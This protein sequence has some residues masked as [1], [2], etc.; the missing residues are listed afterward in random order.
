MA[1]EPDE[2]VAPKPQ[3]KNLEGLSIAELE[4]YIGE[5]ETEIE[6]A[7]TMIKTKKAIRGGADALFKR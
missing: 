3:P 6:R 1:F 4:G 5:L 7:R 2:P